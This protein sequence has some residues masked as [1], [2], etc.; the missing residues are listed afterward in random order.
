M[1]YLNITVEPITPTIGA[2]ISGVD[3]ARELPAPTI[4]EIRAAYLEHLVVFFY[5]QDLRSAERIAFARRFGDIGYYPF[6]AGMADHPEVVEVV[7]KEDEKINF[8]GLWHTDTRYLERPPMGSVLDAVEVPTIGG[9]TLFNHRYLTYD[10]LWPAMQQRLVGLR[11][12]NS[13]EKPDAA[14]TRTHRM[15]DKPKE[16][17]AIV[18][19]RRP[20]ARAHPCGKRAQS[21]LLQQRAYFAYRWHDRGRKSAAVTVSLSG[22]AAR[23]MRLSLSLA[24]RR[25]RIL[26]Q[27]LCSAQCTE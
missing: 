22:A 25:G 20:S 19:H 18:Y 17:H 10:A 12:V 3:L 21:A 23:R 6:V 15:A 5:D 14:V 26:G 24:A 11:A 8:G 7:K 9:D 1:A 13:A 2:V 16:A 4:A 27:S